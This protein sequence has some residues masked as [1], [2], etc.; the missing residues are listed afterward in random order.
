MTTMVGTT[1]EFA[2]NSSWYPDFG[3]TNHITPDI[4][5]LTNKTEL[6]GQDKIVM[7]NGI[8]LSIKHIGQSS[9]Q[10]QFTSKFLSLNHLLHVPSIT[11]NLLSVS[12]FPKDNTMYFE[13]FPNFCYAKYQASKEIP[14]VGRVKNGL[15][16][17]DDFTL[18]PSAKPLSIP[19]STASYESSTFSFQNHVSS[20][21]QYNPE[22]CTA[23][24]DSSGSLNT[25]DDILISG[26]SEQV[27]VHLI[28]SLNREFAL[29][30]LG[31]VNYFLGIE[32]KHIA[33]G[34]HFSQ[35]KYITDLLCKA[36][37]QGA[38]PI[39]TLMT[40]GQK[41]SSYGSESIQDVK[42]YKSIVGAL[43]YVTVTRPENA[44]SVNKVCQYMQAPLESHWKVVKR[45]LRYLKRT[46]YH[47]LH[48]RK[49]P[50]L[51]LVAFCDV[52]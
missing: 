21:F 30:D 35:G 31:E 34:I 47:G 4:H 52:Y 13:F 43:Q 12:K 17:F 28:T 5:N 49:S 26:S 33:K 39:S 7:G 3:A 40:S 36:K 41:L 50:T 29:K 20:H 45:I 42:L 22:S 19:S 27:V 48:L 51:D 1:P 25:L 16:V 2:Y 46:L 44:Y 14:M 18:L 6:V 23:V 38:N 8:G 15:Y 11:K 24:K 32:V 37:M 9:F 10:S